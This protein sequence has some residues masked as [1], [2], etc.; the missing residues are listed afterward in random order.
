MEESVHNG[1]GAFLVNSGQEPGLGL[2]GR[3]L[4]FWMCWH[5]IVTMGVA[6]LDEVAWLASRLGDSDIHLASVN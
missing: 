3:L 1:G 4:S 2:S 6:Y 5:D